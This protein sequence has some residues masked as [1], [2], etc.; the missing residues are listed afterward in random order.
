MSNYRISIMVWTR[1]CKKGKIDLWV[2]AL[3]ERLNFEKYCEIIKQ[4]TKAFIVIIQKNYQIVLNSP[5]FP[6]LN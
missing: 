5:H 2:N 1:I 4:Y 6:D 3:G